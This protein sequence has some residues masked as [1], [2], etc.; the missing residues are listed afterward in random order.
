[1]VTIPPIGRIQPSITVSQS[2]QTMNESKYTV[3]ISDGAFSIENADLLDMLDAIDVDE[4]IGLPLRD[5][6]KGIELASVIQDGQIGY[7]LSMNNQLQFEFKLILAMPSINLVPGIS[8]GMSIVINF[9][10][11]PEWPT[12]VEQFKGVFE[13]AMNFV[14]S[15]AATIIGIIVLA[16]IIW[17]GFL[18]V[19]TLGGG[20]AAAA[21]ILFLYHRG[22]EEDPDMAQKK[23]ALKLKATFLQYNIGFFYFNLFFKSEHKLSN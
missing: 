4:E 17:L 23:V 15:N 21:V 20:A 6:S 2:M 13:P 10:I 7:D 14:V 22:L 9:T 8:T 11:D 19:A 18:G 16:A 3:N 1:M 12:F 5:G